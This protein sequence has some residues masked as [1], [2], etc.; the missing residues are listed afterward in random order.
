MRNHFKYTFTTIFLLFFV[1]LSVNASRGDKTSSIHT[2]IGGSPVMTGTATAIDSVELDPLA[3]NQRDYNVRNRI[4]FGVDMQYPKFVSR[5]QRVEVSV[6]VK[7]FDENNTALS[8][9]NFKLNIAYNH[10]DTL[11]S[12]ILDDYEFSDAYKIIFKIDT[13]RVN[14]DLATTLPENLFVQGDVFVERYSELSTTTI[15]GNPIQFLDVDCNNSYDGI[16]FSWP[17]FQGA[18]EYQLEFMHV[19]DYGVNGSVK[20]EA[21]LNYDFRNNSTRI[22]TSKTFYN[23]GLLFDRGWIAYRVRPVGVDIN[24]PSQLIFGEWSV[25]TTKSTLD[26]IAHLY[27]IQITNAEVHEETLNWQ[28]SATYAEQGKRKEV[29]TYYDGTL[30]NRQAVT[31]VNSNNNVI[32]GETIYDYQGRPALNV[33]PTPVK[34]PDCN[35]NAEPVIKYYSDY[36]LNSQGEPYSK[37]DFDLSPD[38]VCSV[39]AGSMGSISGSS[40]YYSPDNPDKRLHQAYVPDAEGY[41]FQQIEYTPDNTGRINRQGGV[42]PDFQIG[43]GKETKY[44]YGNPTQLELNRLFGSE[45][46]YSEHYQKNIVIDANGQVSVSYIDISGN[47]IATALAGE[48]PQNMNDLTSEPEQLIE[49]NYILPDGSNQVYNDMSNSIIYTSSFILSSPSVTTIDYQMYTLPLL[50]SCLDNICIDC[51]YE[52]ELSLKDDCGVDLLPDTLQHTIGNFQLDSLG[53]YVFHA[54]CADTTEFNTA[55]EVYLEIGKYTLAKRLKIKEEAVLSYLEFIDSSDCVLDFDHFLGIE[56]QNV[57]STTCMITCENCIDELGTMQNF[58]STGQGTSNDYHLRVKECKLLCEEKVSDCEMYFTL[59]KIDFS[60]GGQYAEYLNN[61]TGDLDL[62]NPLSI[63]NENNSFPDGNANWRNPIFETPYGLQNIY[64]DDNGDRSIVIL[65]LDS[66][67]PNVYSPLPQNNDLVQYDSLL[68]DYFIYPEQL[69]K[70][71]DFI[72]LFK[73]SWSSSLVGYHPEY[74]YYETCVQYEEKHSPSDTYSSSS[75]D[76]YYRV[77]ILLMK[78]KL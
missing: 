32:V 6:N 14:G 44:L 48:A 36:N 25:A 27:K 65:T 52:L 73:Q 34:Q 28:Y 68:G 54:Q 16:H 42:G 35:S 20:P 21:S 31:K 50:D 62:D 2:P 10:R 47:V 75:F 37:K 61:S 67:N 4:S 77:L 24:D 49:V 5:K 8:D 13:I 71:E 78:L 69:Q 76:Q 63:F 64:V 39:N 33:L 41:P 59:M 19:S 18:E 51:V 38:T 40:L 3:S 1:Q 46:G 15:F 7:Q 23:I 56:M 30:R 43:S 26:N 72:S 22:T 60:L 11:K 74:C 57:D 55:I 29:I 45:V 9:L 17:D 58:I 70:V 12:I 66:T 53:N